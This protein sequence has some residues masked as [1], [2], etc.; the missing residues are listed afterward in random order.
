MSPEARDDNFFTD[1]IQPDLLLTSK[2]ERSHNR[3][4]APNKT[5]SAGN[6]NYQISVVR[7]LRLDLSYRTFI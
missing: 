2:Q 3:S 6:H 4:K 7:P 5:R 1:D